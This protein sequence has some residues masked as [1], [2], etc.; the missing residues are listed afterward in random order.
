MIERLQ[1]IIASRGLT[2]RRKAEEWIKEGRVT[3]NGNT[4]NLGDV[5]DP[6]CDEIRIDGTLLPSAGQYVYIML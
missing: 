1:K 4:A 6:A 2:S 3:V 5:A